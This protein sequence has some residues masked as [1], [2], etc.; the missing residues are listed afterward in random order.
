M[1]RDGMGLRDYVDVAERIRAFYERYPEG[2]IQTEM[3]RLDGDLA[4]FRATVYRDREDRCPTTGWA[5]EREGNGH[6]NRTSFIENCETSA[7]GR[8]L[9]N[10]NFPTSRRALDRLR[11]EMA[12]VAASEQQER[13]IRALM[14]S[15]RV[16]EDVRERVEA[17]LESGLSARQA[18]DAIAYLRQ[19]GAAARAEEEEEER[20]AA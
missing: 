14:V 2:S 11:R 17:R 8:A 7:I 16:P 10:L 6:V 20:L 12:G 9:A 18:S 4:V 3:V 19:L 5:Y 13:E 15:E 1:A